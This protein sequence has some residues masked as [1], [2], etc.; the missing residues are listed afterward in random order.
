[1]RRSRGLVV[2]LAVAAGLVT[3]ASA[4]A[5]I[6]SVFAGRTVSG[7]PIPCAAQPDGTSVCHGSSGAVDLRLASF[8]GQPLSVYVTLPAGDGPFPL[9]IQSHGWGV[10]TTG[11]TDTQY[12]DPTAD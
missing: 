4:S 11:P 2:L 7:A 10:P 8:D 5:A 6:T 1:M 3:P 9:I 12:Y